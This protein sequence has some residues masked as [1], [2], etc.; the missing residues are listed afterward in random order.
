MLR[1][2]GRVAVVVAILAAVIGGGL[3]WSSRQRE[4]AVTH[5]SA[6]PVPQGERH[7]VRLSPQALKNLSLVAKPLALTT[8]W[9]KIDVPGMIVDRPGVSDRGVVAPVSGIVTRIHAYPGDTVEPNGPLFSMRLVSEQLH[10]SQL[11]LFKATRQIENSQAQI[12]RLSSLSQSGALAQSRIIEIEN[13]VRVLDATAQAYRQD[14]EARGLAADRIQAAANGEFVTEI[15]VKAPGEQALRVAKIALASAEEEPQRLPFNFELHDLKVELGQQVDAGMLLCTLADHRALL[16]EGRGFKDDMPLIQQSVRAGLDVEVVF[17]QSSGANWPA[18][19][20]KFRIHHV[21]NTIEVDSRT[22]AFYLS[23]ENQWQAYTRDGQTRLLWRFR[24][25]DR[26]QLRV[27]VDQMKDVFVVPRDAVV[28]D[29]PEAYVFRQNGTLFDRMPVHILH[30]DQ[31]DIVL[32]NDGTL[33]SGFYVAQN[34]AASL[35]RVLKAQAA[36]GTPANV[37]VHPDGTVHGAH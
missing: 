18:A 4:S 13:Q 16:I 8:Y 34:A 1:T 37:H 14:L 9:Q 27:A 31:R 25:G 36:S 6:A 32:A 26:V 12:Q 30:E 11:E 17:E 15:T 28:R 33:R 7:T 23:L 21:A 35:N 19:P 10:A 2:L 5:A 3:Y 24:P 22:F 29:G 20:S